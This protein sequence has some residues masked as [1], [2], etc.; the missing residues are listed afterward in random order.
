MRSLANVCVL[1]AC[2]ALM[3][4][5]AGA[6]PFEFGS[7]VVKGDADEGKLL[8]NFSGN[9]NPALG[10]WDIGVNPGVY[11]VGDPV[12]LDIA[13][14]SR[15]DANDIRLTD[16]AAGTAGSKVIST[17]ND[18]N[19]P[20]LPLSFGVFYM[21]LDGIPGYSAEDTVYLTNGP[22]TV[23]NDVRLHKVDGLCAGSKVLDFHPDNNKPVLAMLLF[24]VS[25]RTGPIATVRFYNANG[26]YDAAGKPVYDFP[27]SVYLDVSLP[28]ATPFGFVAVNDIRLSS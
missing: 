27:D 7:K 17:D 14:N 15:V 23:S 9:L 11:D 26:N 10:F 12:Y 20:L 5:L 6:T 2:L 1:G 25:P 28:S 24:N 3:L 18:I 22:T 13:N 8:Y 21:E 4:G 19:A 16:S